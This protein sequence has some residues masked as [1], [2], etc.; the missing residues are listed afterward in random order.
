MYVN[1]AHLVSL[2]AYLIVNSELVPDCITSKDKGGGNSL[3]LI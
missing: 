1:S 2:I 3:F